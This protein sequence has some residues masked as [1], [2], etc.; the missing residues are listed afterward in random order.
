MHG[1]L[2]RRVRHLGLSDPFPVDRGVSQG[3]VESPWL[4]ACFIDGLASGSSLLAAGS[5]SL[6]M[7]MTWCSLPL[8][9]GA[10]KDERSHQLRH[11]EQIPAEREEEWGDGLQ[12]HQAPEGSTY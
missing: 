12:H 4:Y 5:L 11:Q 3:A 8:G 10:D 2:T 9:R 7:P 1:N 6:C